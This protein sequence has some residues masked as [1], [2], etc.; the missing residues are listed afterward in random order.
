M[1]SSAEPPSDTALRGDS[2]EIT[3]FRVVGFLGAFTVS[4][5]GS[6]GSACSPLLDLSALHR[7]GQVGGR[8][9]DPDAISLDQPAREPVQQV[10]AAGHDH[11][12]GAAGVRDTPPL[13]LILAL[14]SRRL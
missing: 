6:T 2:E 1:D 4:T 9:L 8:H 10:G 7:V 5:S 14:R 13:P 11:K 3:D 12:G